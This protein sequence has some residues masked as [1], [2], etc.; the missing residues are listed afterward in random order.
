M[1]TLERPGGEA[2]R[3]KGWL[4]AHR[5]LMLRRGAQTGFLAIFLLG[6]WLGWR[7]VDGTLASSRTL[8]VLPLTDPF[9][10]LQSLAAGHRPAVVTD[11]FRLVIEG[12]QMAARARAKNHQHL[13][14]GRRKAA[15]SASNFPAGT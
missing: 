2:V 14:R 6:P 3:V 5:W 15:Q 4:R 1:R 8:G 7:L 10:L 9:V 12:I 11:Q 13:L